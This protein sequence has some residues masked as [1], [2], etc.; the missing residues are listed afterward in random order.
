MVEARRSRS[1]QE[2]TWRQPWRAVGKSDAGCA[3]SGIWSV[4]LRDVRKAFD[5]VSHDAPSRA[6]EGMGVGAHS[7]ALMA[8]AWSLSKIRARLANK[9]SEQVNL[10]RGLPQG[11]AESPI[12]FANGPRTR[13]QTMRRAMGKE[14]L[15][16]K[17]EP[18]LPPPPPQK[19]TQP[20]QTLSCTQNHGSPPFSPSSSTT[21]TR[22][23]SP[24]TPLTP[25]SAHRTYSHRGQ[26]AV[27]RVTVA[28]ITIAISPLEGG[29]GRVTFFFF[30]L[31]PFDFYQSQAKNFS[32]D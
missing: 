21:T 27:R 16:P 31:P 8:K 11:A 12:I 29:R 24:S 32:K 23:L 20:R 25:S 7:R 26:A 15:L 13:G 6:M 2:V 3:E 9:T 18:R 4:T 10:E 28:T 1:S 17:H 22:P 14:R 19:K 30:D 5:H